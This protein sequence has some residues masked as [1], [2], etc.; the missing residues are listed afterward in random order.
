VAERILTP[1]ASVDIPGSDPLLDRDNPIDE[2]LAKEQ[3]WL[4]D[5]QGN[6]LRGHGRDH[7]AHIFFSFAAPAEAV[8]GTLHRLAKTYVTSALAQYRETRRYKELGIPGGVFGN[9]FLSAAGYR[10]LG[11][12]DV[13][14]LFKEPE[15]S[16]DAIFP[17]GPELVPRRTNATAATFARGLRDAAVE[18]FR[19]PPP[20]DWEPGFQYAL[21]ALLLLADDDEHELARQIGP[22]LAI[23]EPTCQVRTIEYGH[24]IRNAN[25]EGIEHFGFVDGRSQP[26]YLASEFNHPTHRTADSQLELI[27]RWDPFEPLRR[28]LIADPLADGAYGSFLVFRKLEQ[29]VRGFRKAIAA[30]AD[31][32]G[33]AGQDAARAGAMVVGRFE[34]GTPLVMQ[35][36]AGWHPTGPNNFDYATDPRGGQCPVHAHIRKVNPRGRTL[37]KSDFDLAG[38]DKA[39]PMEAER[40]RR[41]T[42]RSMTYGDHV[43][44]SK[45]VNTLPERG[46]GVLFMCFQA[47]IRRQFAFMQRHW[48][49]SMTAPEAGAGV[50]VLAGQAKQPIDRTLYRWP[51]GYNRKTRNVVP[52]ESF[53]SMRGGEFFFAP[54]LPFFAALGGRSTSAER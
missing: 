45:P 6:I 20:S 37:A 9:V 25:D 13:E 11:Y 17:E 49:N 12:E 21:H 40:M 44:V 52:F 38:P 7:A 22:A 29:N 39:G 33:L 34:D 28:V 53:I 24:V 19:D 31:E 47:S 32:L 41:I 50:D 36:E 4:K 14:T 48:C 2:R 42:R 5:L 18:E 51:E 27:N 26:A 43:A 54:S 1:E 10:A 15:E 46:V 35:K 16:P 30:L 3:A 23:L 8:K